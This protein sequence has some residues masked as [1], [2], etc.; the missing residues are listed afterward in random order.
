M[1]NRR[2]RRRAHA[3]VQMDRREPVVTL[4]PVSPPAAVAPEAVA[5]ATVTAPASAP[6]P[7]F[8]MPVEIETVDPFRDARALEAAGDTIGA[9]E[10]YQRLLLEEPDNI[11]AR[12]EL[13][14]LFER[15]S[16]YLRALE[17]YEAANA[18]APDNI[19]ILLNLGDVLIALGRYEQAEREFRRAQK[20]DPSRADVFVHAGILQF[21]RGLYL[22][23]DLELRKALELRP[24]D[25]LPH[26][27]RGE[28][29]NQLSRVDEAL[30]A[31]Q[32]SVQLQPTNARA[33]YLMG[34]QYDKKRLPELA[35][36]MYKKARAQHA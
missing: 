5:A 29:L 3:H 17:Q 22:Q 31:L 36:A 35:M 30:D 14:G 10:A 9:I 4:E 19:E 20:L 12:N 11:R 23:G 13:G 28:C 25:P 24:D 1:S 15:L 26:F 8:A 18:L 34:I 7:V 21:K 27:Y 32:R 2:R 6:I 16:L 33:Y